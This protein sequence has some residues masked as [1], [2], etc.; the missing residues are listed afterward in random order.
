MKLLFRRIMKTEI[1]FKQFK[2][3]ASCV[4]PNLENIG[5]QKCLK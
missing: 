5:N 4:E 1:K 2:S 3:Q